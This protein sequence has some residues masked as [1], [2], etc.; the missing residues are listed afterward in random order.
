MKVDIAF[1]MLVDWSGG[2]A[3][4]RGL[5]A[6]RTPLG[7]PQPERKSTPCYGDEQLKVSFN[8]FSYF[9]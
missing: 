5:A 7:K 6:H 2:W 1:R 3:T 4:P 9:Y 8:A